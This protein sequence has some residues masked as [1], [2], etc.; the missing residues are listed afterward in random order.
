MIHFFLVHFLGQD[1]FPLP[2]SPFTMAAL[3]NPRRKFMR[4]HTHF[5]KDGTYHYCNSV[6]RISERDQITAYH[7]HILNVFLSFQITFVL[8]FD[9][10]IIIVAVCGK[11]QLLC[12]LRQYHFQQSLTPLTTREATSSSINMT[13]LCFKMNQ[14]KSNFCE[15][16]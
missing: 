8:A 13:Y 7:N 12:S 10:D 16:P 11:P 5:P 9:K 4:L 14:M 3:S 6:E 2:E 1:L 15:N